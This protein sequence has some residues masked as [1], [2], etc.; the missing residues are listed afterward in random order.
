MCRIFFEKNDDDDIVELELK[1]KFFFVK[2]VFSIFRDAFQAISENRLV[3]WSTFPLGCWLRR[4]YRDT[5]S[6]FTCKKFRRHNSKICKIKVLSKSIFK[7]FS[8]SGIR[9]GNVYLSFIDFI[10]ADQRQIFLWATA[11]LEFR[12]KFFAFL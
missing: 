8:R 4:S 1:L 11:N 5:V 10:I 12:A 9:I 3:N 2:S 6:S 7:E